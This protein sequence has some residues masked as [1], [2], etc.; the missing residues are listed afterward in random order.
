MDQIL[1][2]LKIRLM[3]I[4]IARCRVVHFVSLGIG[5]HDGRVLEDVDKVEEKLVDA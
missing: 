1:Q 3:V 4:A 2:D 5:R